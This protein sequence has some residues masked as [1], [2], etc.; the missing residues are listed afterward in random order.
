MGD[1]MTPMESEPLTMDTDDREVITPPSGSAPFFASEA[2]TQTN[3]VEQSGTVEHDSRMPGQDM[4]FVLRERILA[5]R[6][7]GRELDPRHFDRKEWAG[8]W[9]G[10]LR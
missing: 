9:S 1:P 7:K 2:L 10:R 5:G 3:A 6:K 8:R 4:I